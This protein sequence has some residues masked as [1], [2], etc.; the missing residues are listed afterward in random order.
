[1]TATHRDLL[2]AA[3]GALAVPAALTQEPRTPARL[4]ADQLA[5]VRR[6]TA[7]LACPASAAGS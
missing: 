1:M 7:E 4:D 6:W 5:R 3:L 2:T